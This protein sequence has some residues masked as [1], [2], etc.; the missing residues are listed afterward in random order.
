MRAPMHAPMHACIHAGDYLRHGAPREERRY[1]E[2]RDPA[3]LPALF[4]GFLDEYN[5]LKRGPPLELVMF[6]HAVEHI[7]RIARVLRQPR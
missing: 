1:E 6:M 3:R 4:E 2:V 7:S 5:A